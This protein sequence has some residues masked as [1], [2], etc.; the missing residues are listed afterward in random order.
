M[1]IFLLLGAAIAL[2]IGQT[3]HARYSAKAS[4]VV[5]ATIG[6]SSAEGILTASQLAT[7][8]QPLISNDGALQASVTRAAGLTGSQYAS[9]LRVANP[10]GTVLTITY[11]GTSQAVG[12]AAVTAMSRQLV[13]KGSAGGEIAAHALTQISAPK[14][15]P[16]TTAGQPVEVQA[17]LAVQPVSSAEAAINADPARYLAETYASVIPLDAR[18]QR[19]LRHDLSARGITQTPDLAASSVVNTSVITVVASANTR[20]AAIQ[21]AT[22]TARGLTQPTPATP[23]VTPG[24]LQ[25]VRLPTAATASVGPRSLLA[26]GIVIGLLVGAVILIGW[27]RGDPRIMST[28]QAS[29]ALGVP[30][31]YTDGANEGTG[32]GL[33][34]RW[35]STTSVDRVMI[36]PGRRSVRRTAGSL[37]ESLQAAARA[38]AGRPSEAPTLDSE[39]DARSDN[40][41]SFAQVIPAGAKGDGL[42]LQEGVFCVLVLP[43]GTRTK[44]AHR[45]ADRVNR[46]GGQVDWVILVNS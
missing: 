31:S 34:N 22:I 7:I 3:R 23:S 41:H 30:T 36:V 9:D 20:R 46:T 44:L 10:A 40:G 19:Y 12:I 42:A 27:M 29:G 26:P 24:T 38:N 25:V 15:S 8:Y 17:V 39:D 45:L 21:E 32:V 43:T 35:R 18:L 14:V 6:S 33:L 2:A 13:S 37:A 4:L 5:P 11:R 28:D 16:D 1:I